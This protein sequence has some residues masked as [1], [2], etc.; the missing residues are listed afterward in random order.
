M[1][2]WDT[3]PSGDDFHALREYV[4]PADK[5]RILLGPPIPDDK[6]QQ[7]KET[8]LPEPLQPLKLTPRNFATQALYS[9]RWS[10]QDYNDLIQMYQGRTIPIPDLQRLVDQ[11][12]NQTQQA[13]HRAR[14]E[15]EKEEETEVTLVDSHGNPLQKW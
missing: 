13:P 10:D 12:L 5:E 1:A 14:V 4:K 8:K 15:D 2:F 11:F 9:Q 3:L 6:V 7:P